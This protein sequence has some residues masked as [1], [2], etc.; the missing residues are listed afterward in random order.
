[1]E[2]AAPLCGAQACRTNGLLYTAENTAFNNLLG[3]GPAGQRIKDPESSIAHVGAIFR[4]W[5]LLG[6]SWALLGCLLGACWPLLCVSWLLVGVLGRFFAV[7]DWSRLDFGG[8]GKH[9]G[10][11]LE[12]LRLIF[13]RFLVH[14]GLLVAPALDR[15]KPWKNQGFSKVFITLACCTQDQK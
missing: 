5:A 12:P 3:G 1:M 9:L 6:R 2:S 13:R 4:S 7:W 8:F 14:T 15:Q 11:F 10:T